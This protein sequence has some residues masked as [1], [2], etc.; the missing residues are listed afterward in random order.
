LDALPEFETPTGACDSHFHVFGPEGQYPYAGQLR[1]KPPHAPLDDYLSLAKGLGF[2]RFVF[3][4]PSAYGRDNSCMLD[5]MRLMNRDVCRGIVDVEDDVS[6]KVLSEMHAL[7]V[8]GLRINVSPV[9]P[10]EEG[11]LQKMLPR[12][13][14]WDAR[15]AELGWH[16]DFLLP[17]WLTEEMLPTL[18]KLKV[19][20]SLAHMGMFL[21]VNGPQQKGFQNLLRLLSESDGKTWIKF[22][23]TY[24]MATAPSF[25]DARP[26]AQAILE[27]NSNRVIWGSDY[28]HLSFADQVG[29][30]ALFNLLKKWAPDPAIRKKILTDNPKQLFEF[31]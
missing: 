27:A 24:R 22:T 8:R 2:Q 4:Q 7:G 16:I 14:R 13:L 23:G 10:R 1:Y 19:N 12:I 20:H 28:P 15:C 5:A 18:Q 21:A 6:D 26:M 17:G 29:S 11:L 30:V 25:A 31:N 9:N 3:V